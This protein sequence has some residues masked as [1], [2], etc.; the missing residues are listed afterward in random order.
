MGLIDTFT[1]SVVRE[2]G[3]N[4]GKGISNDLFGDWHATPI[5]GASSASRK[6]GWDISFVEPEEFDVSSQPE[7]KG[8]G[9]SIYFKFVTNVIL[10]FLYIGVFL[11]PFFTIKDFTRKKTNLYA[12]VPKRKR[13]GRT[14]AGYIDLGE[15]AWIQLKS[16]RLLTDEEKKRSK[17]YGLVELIAILVGVILN[18]WFIL[19]DPLDFSYWIDLYKEVTKTAIE[20]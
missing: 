8:E 9:S 3:R 15:D 7:W 17:I 5:R 1:R 18:N 14:K 2:V 19:G 16:K 4:V 12:R 20:P 6:Q 10:S 11:L 13:D